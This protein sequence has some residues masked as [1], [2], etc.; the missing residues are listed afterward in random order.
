MLQRLI[1]N[2]GVAGRTASTAATTAGGLLDACNGTQLINQVDTILCTQQQGMGL[3]L[4]RWL[5]VICI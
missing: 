5:W 4:G 1:L 2:K 3:Q